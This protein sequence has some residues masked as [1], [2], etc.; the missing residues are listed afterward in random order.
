MRPRNHG[1]FVVNFV[2]IQNNRV[3][4]SF[5]RFILHELIRKKNYKQLNFS[6]KCR[7]TCPVCATYVVFRD[8]T[9]SQLSPSIYNCFGWNLYQND[10]KLSF[11][12]RTYPFCKI[13]ILYL[14]ITV[15]VT[16]NIGK[17]IT[18][19]CKCLRLTEKSKF[20]YHYRTSETTILLFIKNFCLLKG[21]ANYGCS[22]GYSLIPNHDIGCANG[23]SW[24]TF[25][26]KIWLFIIFFFLINSCRIKRLKEI[27]TLLFC[28]STK[29][30]T[31]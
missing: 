3:K 7:S 14:N 25:F 30:T 12:R 27:F 17:K 24:P 5:K 4:I 2:D 9:V 13:I 26:T 16:K 28:M 10:R 18:F 20:Q 31:N 11:F 22:L 6:K 1:S 29:L 8:Q 23:T 15:K 19:F 21:D